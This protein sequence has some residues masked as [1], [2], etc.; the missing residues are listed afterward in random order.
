MKNYKN[1]N[2]KIFLTMALCVFSNKA[3]SQTNEIINP[4]GKWFFGGEMGLNAIISVHPSRMTSFQAGLLA[5]Y[6]FAKNW[7]VN[8]RIKYFETGVIHEN[9]STHGQF[10]GAV[11]SL[12]LNLIW[13]YRIIKNFSGNFKLGF[14]L[15]QEIKSN[16]DYPSNEKTDYSKFYGSFNPGL[17]F[18]YFISDKTAVFMNYEVFILGNNRTEN[19][20]L[21]LTPN[22]PNNSLFNIGIKHDFLF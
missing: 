9:N 3:T 8:G 22:S 10:E 2:F 15:N 21:K 17:G 12:P 7:S 20:M 4:K 1:L 6:Y 11:L 14:A 5:E 18:N 16:Y 13:K 19:N